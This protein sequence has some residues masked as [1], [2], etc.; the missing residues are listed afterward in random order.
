MVLSGV[1]TS[2]VS[3]PGVPFVLNTEE[4]QHIDLVNQLVYRQVLTVL[5]EAVVI[6]VIWTG[7]VHF[8]TETGKDFHVRPGHPGIGDVPDNGNLQA[9]KVTEVLMDSHHIQETLRRVLTTTVA[10]IDN[11]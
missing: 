6:P 10:S 3:I 2:F 9:G 1:E 7:E 5:V 11:S 8:R 4:H